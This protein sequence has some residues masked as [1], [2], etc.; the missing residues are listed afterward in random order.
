MSRLELQHAIFSVLPQLS[1]LQ[2]I[3]LLEFINAML[4]IKK[5]QKEYKTPLAKMRQVQVII[6][7]SFDYEPVEIPP[8][9]L[10]KNAFITTVKGGK[11]EKLK[12]TIILE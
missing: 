3:K 6:D 5:P 9:L 8:G 11:V 4:S 1:E 2:Q 10:S 7:E 12:P